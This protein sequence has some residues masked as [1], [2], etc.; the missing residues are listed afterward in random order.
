ML[1]LAVVGKDVS[2]SES[3]KMHAFI[4]RGLG[5]DC[6]YEHIS[7]A[8][9]KFD[10]L[11]EKLLAEKDAF[12]VTIPYKLSVIPHLNSLEG[13]AK[14]FG[15]VNTVKDRIG[16]NTDGAGFMLMLQNNGIE[17][18]GR[19]FLVLGA[20]GAGRSVVKKLADAG[21]HVFLYDMN[22]QNAEI[23]AK[24]F[25]NIL[26]LASLQPAQ[27][28]VIV[29]ATGVGMHKSEG[30]SPVGAEFLSRCNI[31]CDLIYCPKKSEFLRIAE[32]L[33]KKILNGEGML[34]YQAYYADCIYLGKDADPDEAKTLFERY[35]REKE[36][37]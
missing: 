4:L 13:D 17:L 27:Y 14:I 12:N 20:G 15:A 9:E 25:G 26:P 35:Q 3:G 19:R 16:Y 5:S 11:A 21:A 23:V 29:N 36:N 2:K 37:A 1:K 31:A 10:A 7:V 34:F 30:V 8:A 6:E 33:G 24:E 32:G 28:D 22:V 18:S